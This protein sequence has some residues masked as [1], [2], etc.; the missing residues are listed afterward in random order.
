MNADKA[1]EIVIKVFK[2]DFCRD[3]CC[4]SNKAIILNKTNLFEGYRIALK[5]LEDMWDDDNI[6]ELNYNE[7]K[8]AINYLYDYHKGILNNSMTME[9]FIDIPDFIGIGSE[10]ERIYIEMYKKYSVGDIDEDERENFIESFKRTYCLDLDN[11][12]E[13]DRCEHMIR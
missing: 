12:D 13:V 1:N 7:G 11:D 2:K 9:E 8:E 4:K 6:D 5:T 10:L 3:F